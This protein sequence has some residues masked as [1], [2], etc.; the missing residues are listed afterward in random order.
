MIRSEYFDRTA[1]LLSLTPSQ[2]KRYLFSQI[3]WNNRCIG[4]FG[5]RGT[6][7]TTML[8]QFAK[9]ANY[10]S[11]ECLYISCDS[12]LVLQDGIYEI[13]SEFFK[14]GGKCLILDEAHRYPK[15]G[16]HVKAL[17]DAYPKKQIILSGSS[18]LDISSATADLSRRVTM[19]EL[20]TLSFREFLNIHSQLNLPSYSLTQ[21]LE[22]TFKIKLDSTIEILKEFEDYL[23]WGNLPISF[24]ESSTE[25]YLQKLDQLLDK[26]L[27]EDIFSSIS[28]STSSPIIMKKMIA[29]IASS[30]SYILNT[31]KVASE[32]K[33]HRTT[34]L[35]YIDTMERGG[36]IYTLYP[37]A[38]G[39][40][41]IRKNLKIG[42]KF[43]NLYWAIFRSYSRE[44]NLR[45]NI[46]E[47]FFLSQ[48]PKEI[49]LFHQNKGDYFFKTDGKEFNLE[50]GGPNK[51]DQQIKGLTNAYL[52]KDLI[53]TRVLNHIPL[54][55]FGFLY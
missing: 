17:Y 51:T 16:N 15:W 18:T 32:L 7:K 34:L 48:F 21:M 43:P 49:Q 5:F 31:E 10:Q 30:P 4:I 36:I 2:W 20:R 19:Y 39:Y 27:Y 24:S 8:L 9:E 54:Y 23:H 22:P 41:G 44:D 42:L 1:E 47:S 12:P 6:G 3:D 45:G 53:T 52:V 29:L 35:N 13:G 38:E 50:I 40:G 33:I 46:R 25:S 11:E 37:K 28:H 55:Y 14:V 26:V